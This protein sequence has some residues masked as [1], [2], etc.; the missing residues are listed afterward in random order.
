MT[1]LADEV[2]TTPD[3]EVNSHA[4]NADTAA[5]GPLWQL[6]ASGVKT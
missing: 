6:Q 4:V 3:C 1:S 2:V 5:H